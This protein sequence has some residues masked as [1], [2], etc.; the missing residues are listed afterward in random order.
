M[1]IDLDNVQRLLFS[2]PNAKPN[3]KGLQLRLRLQSR[4]QHIPYIPRRLVQV[5]AHPLAAQLLGH[6][7]EL[8][9]VAHIC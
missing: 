5:E 3:A 1:D 4:R 6:D 7:V 2:L 8:D 9:T